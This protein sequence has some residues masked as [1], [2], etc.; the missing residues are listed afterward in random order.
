MENKIFNGA[1]D[2]RVVSLPGLNTPGNKVVGTQFAGYIP[3]TGTANPTGPDAGL[4]YWFVGADDYASR[5]TVIWTNGGPGSSSFWGFFLENGPYEIAYAKGGLGPELTPREHAWNQYANYMIFEHPLSVTMSFAKDDQVPKT[6]EQGME[7]YY[8][9]LLNFLA[10]HPELA[11]NPIIL[12]GESYA[13][14]YLPLLAKLIAEGNAKEGGTRLNLCGTV[15]LDAWVDPYV[16][17]AMDTTYAL[18]RGIISAKQKEMLDK[19]VKLPDVAFKIQT[20]SGV[21]MANVAETGDPSFDPVMAYLNNADFRTA[22]HAP[23]LTPATTII[24]NWSQAVSDNYSKDDLVNKSYADVV[25]GLLEGSYTNG[26]F[27][28]KIIVISGLN[29]AKD[30]NFL[31]TGEWLNKLDGAAA[32]AF[33]KADTTQWVHPESKQVLG[34]EQNGGALRWLKVLN[35]GHLAVLDQPQLIQYILDA[36]DVK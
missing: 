4:F 36:V 23:A 13:G 27:K 33:K 17:M 32:E 15:L 6:V 16:Q 35:A 3:V 28:Q 29:D 19:E 30:C 1:T 5:P 8:Q 12:A 14:T 22:V 26:K 21:Y 25:K 10:K 24:Q 20:L 11:G 7:Q 31:G 18:N 34:F 9:A 2:D